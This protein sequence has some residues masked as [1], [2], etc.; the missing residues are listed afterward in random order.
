MSRLFKKSLLNLILA[1][2]GLSLFMSCSQAQQVE[3]N[4]EVESI[5]IEDSYRK[6]SEDVEE[7]W[8]EERMR[9]AKPIPFPD[10]VIPKHGQ[11]TVP[12]EGLPTDALP[13]YTPGNALGRGQQS[14]HSN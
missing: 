1:F 12:Q 8:T 6:T 10:A 11:E 13:G 7:Y 4:P 3:D 14:D 2:A 5:G 9:K